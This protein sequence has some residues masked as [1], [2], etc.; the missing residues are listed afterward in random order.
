[1]GKG[2][3]AGSSG[4]GNTCLRSLL[5]L[6]GFRRRDA[7]VPP[8]VLPPTSLACG[9]PEIWVTRRYFRTFYLAA[10]S[11]PLC[12]ISCSELAAVF[13][14]SSKRST[15]ISDTYTRGRGRIKAGTRFCTNTSSQIHRHAH[16][17][18]TLGPLKTKNV[19]PLAALYPCYLSP[20]W[21]TNECSTS[22]S[23][24]KECTCM[25]VHVHRHTRVSV[26]AYP[27]TAPYM[28]C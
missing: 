12:L 13:V 5:H 6:H 3:T 16:P 17:C 8:W 9:P 19:S 2:L 26:H 21:H 20:G 7:R 22:V 23:G 4:P 27:Q 10:N 14:F 25:Y 28:R 24:R 1:M 18:Q 15:C 11:Q